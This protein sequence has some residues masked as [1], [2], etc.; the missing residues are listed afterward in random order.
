M[1]SAKVGIYMSNLRLAAGALRDYSPPSLNSL[2][3]LGRRLW[4]NWNEMCLLNGVNPPPPVRK[5]GSTLIYDTL[6]NHRSVS[7]V[8]ALRTLSKLY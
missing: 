8:K 3:H 4:V 1:P 2:A 7:V 5:R 6:P